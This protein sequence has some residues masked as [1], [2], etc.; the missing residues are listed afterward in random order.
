MSS[1]PEACGLTHCAQTRVLA[2]KNSVGE[3]S[4]AVAG[5]CLWSLSVEAKGGGCGG[6]EASRGHWVAGEAC[7][8]ITALI[9][10]PRQPRP[11]RPSRSG[12]GIRSDWPVT[13]LPSL[14]CEGGAEPAA[15][16]VSVFPYL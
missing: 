7:R 11:L 5:R 4:Y 6:S 15:E 9:P 8:A 2:R 10:R 16:C 13:L 14:T 3:D 12:E 1:Y